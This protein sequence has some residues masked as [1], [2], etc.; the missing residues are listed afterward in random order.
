[1]TLDKMLILEIV[2]FIKWLA[3]GGL[4]IVFAVYQINKIEFRRSLTAGR[5]I[6]L[7]TK[8]ME[9]KSRGFVDYLLKEVEEKKPEE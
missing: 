8:Q 6:R 1:M 9:D 4:L 2:S 3:I 5:L 7:F